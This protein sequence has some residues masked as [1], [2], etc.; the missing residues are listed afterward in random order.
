MVIIIKLN[1]CSFNK[2][3]F[4]ILNRNCEWFEIHIADAVFAV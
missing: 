4:Y 1:K 3:C 2:I